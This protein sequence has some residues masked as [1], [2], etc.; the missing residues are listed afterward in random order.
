MLLITEQAL[1]VHKLEGVSALAILASIW[2]WD[3]ASVD[4]LG[5]HVVASVALEGCLL[6]FRDNI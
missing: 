3:S 4:Q 6:H 5:L 1:V 2:F